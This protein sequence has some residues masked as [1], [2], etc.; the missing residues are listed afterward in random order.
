[1]ASTSEA[2]SYETLATAASLLVSRARMLIKH[3]FSCWIGI[4]LVSCRCSS[5][6]ITRARL[7][8]LASCLQLIY[9]APSLLLQRRQPIVSLAK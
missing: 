3:S 7:E 4:I 2:T 9:S 8:E 1:M 6:N 5:A